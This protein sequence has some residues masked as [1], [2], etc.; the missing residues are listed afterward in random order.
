MWRERQTR[1]YRRSNGLCYFCAEPYNATH[2]DVCTKRP[3]PQPQ[4]NALVLNELDVVLTGEVLDQLAIEDALAA[5]FYQLSLHAIAGTEVGE[6]MK[7][8]ALVNNKVMLILLDIGSS[9]SFVSNTFLSTVGISALPTTLR[10]VR[11][12]NGDTLITDQWV[13][14]LS[15]WANGHTL[16]TDMRVLPLGAYD[17]ILGYD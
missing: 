17:A 14:Q 8:R 13:H 9:H 2:K 6:A 16:K 10:Q 4:A 15:W 1:D 7:I 11:L 5:D 3:Q 12:A